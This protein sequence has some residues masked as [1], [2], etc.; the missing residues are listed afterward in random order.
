[1]ANLPHS[2]PMNVSYVAVGASAQNAATSQ[3][4][5]DKMAA[6]VEHLVLQLGNPELR[7]SALHELSKVDCS[8]TSH[9]FENSLRKFMVSVFKFFSDG[10]LFCFVIQHGLGKF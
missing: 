5:K 6:A 3:A 9:K 7:E 4:N 2:F 10:L 8:F 1:M